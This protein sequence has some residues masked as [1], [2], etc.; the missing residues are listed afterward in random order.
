MV[1][2]ALVVEVMKATEATEPDCPVCKAREHEEWVSRL[3]DYIVEV[4]AASYDFAISKTET[5]RER[6]SLA[7]RLLREFVLAKVQEQSKV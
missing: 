4:S 7:Q 2:N 5:A 6:G 1:T 3:D